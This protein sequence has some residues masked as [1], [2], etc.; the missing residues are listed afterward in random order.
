MKTNIFIV[1]VQNILWEIDTTV[2]DIS[3]ITG[4]A[5]Q[6]KY[7]AIETSDK[8][9]PSSWVQLTCNIVMFTEDGS[10]QEETV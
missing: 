9:F 1:K 5:D 8:Y 7:W 6:T 2:D 3:I 10:D 4:L